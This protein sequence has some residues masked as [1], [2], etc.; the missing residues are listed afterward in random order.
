MIICMGQPHWDD[1]QVFLAVSRTG[2]LSSAARTLGVDQ[3][4][5]SRRLAEMTARLGVALLERR[6]GRYVPTAAGRTAL[7]RAVRV[8]DELDALAREVGQADARLSGSVHLSAPAGLGVVLI[9]PRLAQFHARHP[10]IDL[11][12]SA[13]TELANLSRREADVAL[14]FARSQQGDLVV[15]RIARV[16]FTLYASAQYLK[17]RPREGATIRPDDELIL[18]H[19]ESGPLLEA[20]WH[21]GLG[22]RLRM[23]VRNPLALREATIAGAG[24]ALLGEYLARHPTLRALPGAEVTLRDLF[25]VFHR[26]LRSSARVRAVCAFAEECVSGGI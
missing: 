15:R 2:T 4:T 22:G 16:P 14:R 1:L 21:E 13:E 18:M 11:V 12:V 20:T 10:G 26:A 19:E 17:R 3:S 23:R 7:P 8:E 24:I 25:L 9:A 5:V 6:D